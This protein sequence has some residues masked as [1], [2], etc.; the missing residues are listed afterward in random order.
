MHLKGD[1]ERFE[2]Q[3]RRREARE[4]KCSN[5]LSIAEWQ[6]PT[7][8]DYNETQI[9]K[10]NYTKHVTLNYSCNPRHSLRKQVQNISDTDNIHVQTVPLM[11]NSH[12]SSHSSLIG[13]ASGMSE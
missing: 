8:T 9:Y 3:N 12:H 4:N 13:K 10:S 2:I 5:Y 11:L 6:A 7:K 1:Y